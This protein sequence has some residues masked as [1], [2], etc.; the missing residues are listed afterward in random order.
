[1]KRDEDGTRYNVEAACALAEAQAEVGSRS[2]RAGPP[3]LD[4]IHSAD[5][6]SPSAKNENRSQILD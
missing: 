1:V 3:M 5:M 4:I 2:N 6:P